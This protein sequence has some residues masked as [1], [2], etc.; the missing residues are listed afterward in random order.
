[1]KLKIKVLMILLLIVQTKNLY[2]Q[3][4][5]ENKKNLENELGIDLIKNYSGEEVKQLIQIILE[6]ADASIDN[7]YKEGYKQA[8]VELLPEVEYWKLLYNDSKK[9]KIQDNIKL[10]LISFGS[11]FLIGGLSGFSIGFNITIN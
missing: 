10:S 8:T 2:S 11:G 7:A 4:F 3:T 1:M 5:K 6:E 9:S